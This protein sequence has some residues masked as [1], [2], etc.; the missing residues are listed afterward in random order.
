MGEQLLQT[1]AMP[2]SFELG[3]IVDLLTTSSAI[4]ALLEV[5]DIFKVLDRLMPGVPYEDV[6]E[7]WHYEEIFLDDSICRVAHVFCAMEAFIDDPRAHV[8]QPQLDLARRNM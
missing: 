7:A 5:D 3:R 8:A 4:L 2:L 1:A 6:M